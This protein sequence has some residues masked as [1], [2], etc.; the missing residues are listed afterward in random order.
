[1]TDRDPVLDK[2][3]LELSKFCHEQGTMSVRDYEK[4]LEHCGKKEK[5]VS[6]MTSS[7]FREIRQKL[8]LSQASLASL[9]G[10]SLAS[11]A[12]YEAGQKISNPIAILMRTMNVHGIQGLCYT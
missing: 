8:S 1:M 3:I 5:L 11:V 12:K 2:T 7:Q 6:P 9:I 10:V 4:I